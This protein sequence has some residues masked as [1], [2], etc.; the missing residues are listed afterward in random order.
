MAANAAATARSEK[1]IGDVVRLPEVACGEVVVPAEGDHAA[2]TSVAVKLELAEG[3]F[4]HALE[5]RLLVGRADQPRPVAE[6]LGK[7][8]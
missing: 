8:R 7:V 4:A 1:V 6:S 3:E 2:A 5:K